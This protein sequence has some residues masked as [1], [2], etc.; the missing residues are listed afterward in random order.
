MI[1]LHCLASQV[2]CG[3]ETFFVKLVLTSQEYLSL[4]K[5]CIERTFFSIAC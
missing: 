2:P 4:I 3:L 5:V 1:N